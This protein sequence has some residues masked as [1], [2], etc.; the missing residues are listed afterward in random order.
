MDVQLQTNSLSFFSNS[1]DM[2][3]KT[4]TLEYQ[5]ASRKNPELRGLALKKS[6]LKWV[7][8]KEKKVPKLFSS[9]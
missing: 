8:G 1:E 7:P 4:N 6:R 2:G 9:G 5:E 3:Q